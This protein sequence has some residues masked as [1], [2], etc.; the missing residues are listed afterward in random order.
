LQIN[1]F[2][3]LI[4]SYFFSC[5]ADNLVAQKSILTNGDFEIGT[6]EICDC[7]KGYICANDAGRVID[8][9]HQIYELGGSG[10]A[11]HKINYSNEL[12][13]HSGNG[14]IYFYAGW[15]QITY[16]EP[17]Y[18]DKPQKLKLCIWYAGPQK[19]GA[20]G[21]NSDRA[22]FSI[23]VDNMRIGPNVAVPLNTAWTQYCF[24]FTVV[25]GSYNFSI[26]SGEPAAYAIWFDDLS[27][28]KTGIVTGLSNSID[29]GNG[30]TIGV[31]II[32]NV[33]IELDSLGNRIRLI[34]LVKPTQYYISNA[35]KQILVEG[36]ADP[37]QN[38]I[39]I[40]FLAKGDY[41]QKNNS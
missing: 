38:T 1:H 14:Y 29:P 10:C 36:S 34:N 25:E 40:D 12:G 8:G 26:M 18:F 41:M 37:I 31:R 39:N 28:E 23:G 15:D 7:P 4:I 21:Q 33:Q 16:G 20:G 9:I 13:A 3:A 35:W 11:A 6:Y 24:S 22:F 2:R 17:I 27:I 19:E 30:D 32:P 5:F